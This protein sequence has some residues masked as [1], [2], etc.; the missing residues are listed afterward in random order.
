MPTSRFRGGVERRGKVV[1]SARPAPRDGRFV[2]AVRP[3][4]ADA[5]GRGGWGGADAAA[6]PAGGDE[7]VRYIRPEVP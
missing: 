1:A 3:G 7:E 5:A 2:R 6:K 4:P